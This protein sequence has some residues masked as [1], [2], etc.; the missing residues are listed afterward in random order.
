MT[1]KLSIVCGVA[2]TVG[3]ILD[4]DD[5]V[6]F[7][8]APA[9]GDEAQRRPADA[10]DIVLGR[11]KTAAPALDGAF[12]DIGDGVDAFLPSR[13]DE[14]PPAEGALL[15]L[16]VWRPALGGKGAVLSAT[17]KAGLSPQQ[18]EEL[19]AARGAP[20][21]ISQ[22]FDPALAIA[23]R[24]AALDVSAIVIDRPETQRALAAAGVKATCDERAFGEL[25]IEEALSCAL[26]PAVPLGGGAQMIITETAGGAV[27]D[28]D[29]GSASNA[30]RRPNDAV[31]A[32]A[33]RRLLGELSRRAIG[34]RVV[35][36]FLP[37]S[38]PSQRR[39]LLETL[40][41]APKYYACRPG[42]LAP[43]GLFDL[44]APR[45]DLSLLERASEETDDGLLRPGRRFTL[46]WTA[47]RAIAALEA[48]LARHPRLKL[49][50]G[51]A[52]E[53]ARY[54]EE[55]PHWLARLADRYGPRVAVA[56]SATSPRSFDVREL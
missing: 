51:A 25:D 40:G 5:I 42:K 16:G 54:I 13:R 47:K 35:V 9:R 39:S 26:A 34:G 50:L 48:R 38:S 56:I 53:I 15:T 28:V 32:L 52:P 36:D 23:R 14:K 3:V 7:F 46:D 49:S 1:L 29:T 43:D 2:E 30:S 12:V 21:L 8:F 55:R 22:S 33:A 20:R 4:D 24:A 45:R 44:T 31:N 10:G 17:W 41:V 6:R 37:P 27:I 19:S 11:I 18:V